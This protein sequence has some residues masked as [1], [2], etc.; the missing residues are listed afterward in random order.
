MTFLKRRRDQRGSMAMLMPVIMVTSGLVLAT[1]FAVESGQRST[2]RAGDSA[3]ALQV[4]DAGINA[5]V[6]F[7]PGVPASQA[8][9]GPTSASIGNG[10]YTYSATKV[11]NL[12]W[13]VDS[14]GV[15]H[16]GLTRRIKAQALGAPLFGR[17]LVVRNTGTFS[18][19]A[20]LDSF[21]GPTA[22]CT[23]QGILAII[24]PNAVIYGNS[25]N[26]AN[27]QGTYLNN[28]WTSANDGCEIP[29]DESE[30]ADP[31]PNFSN[32]TGSGK[33]PASNTKRVTPKFPQGTVA[34]PKIWNVPCTDP[35]GMCSAP[36]PMGSSYVCTAATPLLAGKTY[37]YGTITLLDGC[38]VQNVVSS[39]PVRLFAHNFILG[40]DT[41]AQNN[42]INAPQAPCSPYGGQIPPTVAT[43]YCAGW[44]AKLQINLIGAGEVRFKNK[45]RFMW[46]VI[47]APQGSVFIETPQLEFW[48]ASV[49]NSITSAAQFTWHFDES[50]VNEL[51]NGFYSV[52]NW[53]E[54]S[55]A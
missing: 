32:I 38:I 5:A 1:L 14:V 13:N 46:G 20:I 12:L 27:C 31:I 26:Q 47:N 45:A 50:L 21:A 11:N 43:A 49:S 6:Q 42:V 10:T 25:G 23:K 37:Y 8:S 29:S 19:G 24:D 48:G 30:M 51:G 35:S 17:P 39:G 41:G 22:L 40:Q 34:A 53:R 16:N 2:R 28:G 3:N 44:S 36:A 33:C 18:S 9:V 15:D 7:L 52:E 4:A 55:Q 54:E